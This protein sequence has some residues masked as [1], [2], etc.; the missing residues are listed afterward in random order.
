MLNIGTQFY[1]TPQKLV[2][3]MLMGIDWKM[4]NSV[5][6][7]SAGSGNILDGISTKESVYRSGYYGKGLDVDC[8]EIDESLR[9]ILKT[10]TDK[11]KNGLHI[12]HDDFLTYQAYKKYDLIVMNPPFENGD[13]HLL[14]ALEMQKSGGCIVCLLNAET[15]LNPY[16][17]SRKNLA[18]KLKEYNAEIKYIKNAFSDAERKTDVEI[19][20]IRV[21]IPQEQEESEIYQRF[22]KAAEYE[23]TPVM[24]QELEVTDYIKAAV[25]MYNIEVKSGIEL[26]RQYKALVP[27]MATN[28]GEDS[29]NKKPIL[30]LTDSTDRGYESVSINDYLKRVRLKYWKALLSNEKFTNK[31]TTD[32]RQKYQEKVNTFADYDFSEFNIKT[33]SAEMNSE[34]KTGIEDEII[35]MYEKMTEEHSYY[36]ECTKNR[37]YYDGWCTNKAHK[38]GKKVILPCYGV[39]SQYDGRS[40]IYD[41]NKTIFD[42]EKVLNYFDGNMTAEVNAYET[43]RRYFDAGETKNIPLKFFKVTFYKKGTMHI[44]FTCPELIERYNIYYAKGKQWLPPCYGK[45]QYEDM[46]EHEKAVIDSFQG[47]EAYNEVLKR[48]DYYLAQPVKNNVL[49]L[50][51]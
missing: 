29:Y 40:R 46:T 48:A 41:V 42:L 11:F 39:F 13:L 33:L 31:L 19:A 27:Y 36:T 8:I 17:P 9:A 43:V 26:I 23:D 12:V 37:H 32:L 16:T 28:F 30:R 22:K 3:E 15:L 51:E 25:N 35:K 24:S 38:I 45:K 7:P 2:S 4:I 14:K 44:E 1:P 10:K 21:N 6:E 20:M 18:A 49:M 5:L 47:K 50:E 34:V